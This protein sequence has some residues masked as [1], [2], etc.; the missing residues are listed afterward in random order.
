MMFLYRAVAAH[1]DNIFLVFFKPR[2]MTPELKSPAVASSDPLGS[3][4]VVTIK[5]DDLNIP[6]TE[7]K[8]RNESPLSACSWVSLAYGVEGDLALIGTLKAP[9]ELARILRD[10]PCRDAVYRFRV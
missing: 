3:A 9:T 10:L 7:A 5:A 1:I 2:L 4:S 8:K 6:A